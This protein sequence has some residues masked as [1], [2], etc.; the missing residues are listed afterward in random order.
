MFSIAI[1][2]IKV[3]KIIISRDHIGE[4]PL[5]YYKNKNTFIFGSELKPI[6]YLL[7]KNSISI[8][9]DKDSI[10]SY[11]V[12]G[13][14]FSEYN[15]FENIK[16][17]EPSKYMILNLKENISSSLHSYWNYKQIKNID[18][19]NENDLIENID[20]ILRNDLKKRINS[21]FPVCLFFSGG[22]D[23]SL[24]LNYLNELNLNNISL[25]TI[26]SKIKEKNNE[27]EYYF[28]NQLLSENKDRPFI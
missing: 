23:S 27:D 17:F 21:S 20:Y 24:L 16:S 9:L 25:V 15:M 13:H 10:N 14:N 22:I 26:R 19:L 6:I 7:K 28:Q 18:Y 8:N 11:L 5:Y 3:K 2:D 1:Y 12:Y 4:K